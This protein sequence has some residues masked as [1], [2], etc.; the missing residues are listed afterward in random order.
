MWVTTTIGFFSAV[1]KTGTDFITV[2]A[3]ARDDLDALRTKYL[4][5]LTETQA[6]T[7]T[8][9]PYRATCSREAWGV[10]MLHLSMDVDYSNFKSTV[11]SRVGHERAQVYSKVWS[12]LLDITKQEGQAATASRP[13]AA[14]T[15]TGK[16]EPVGSA[17]EPPPPDKQ[18]THSY[19]GVLVDDQGRVLLREPTDH[20]GGYVWTFPKGKANSGETA[21]QAALRETREEVGVRAEIVAWLPQG[22]LGGTGTTWFALM[23][24]IE[25]L[26]DFQR[27]ETQAV[28]WCTREEAVKHL[29][30]TTDSRG[31]RRDPLVLAEAL[32][33]WKTLRRPEASA[34]VAPP[35]GVG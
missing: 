1:Q 17:Y 21:A 13:R 26:G 19:G 32:N 33:L 20:Y 35:Q 5:T 14:T 12:A 23:R 16:P 30:Q 24:V 2:R 27:K 31:R 18:R 34:K 29:D 11:T 4:P 25:D 9:Y 28:R 22:F 6:H 10:A 15:P 3:R 7:G 8:D